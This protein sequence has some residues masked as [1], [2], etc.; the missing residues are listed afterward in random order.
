MGTN[1]AVPQVCKHRAAPMHEDNQ[2]QLQDK[3]PRPTP[4]VWVSGKS[5]S[6]VTCVTRVSWCHNA[7]WVLRCS[8]FSPSQSAFPSL[9][10]EH[11]RAGVGA[12]PVIYS[13]F[14]V[15]RQG[16][17]FKSKVASLDYSMSCT[18]KC[19]ATLTAVSQHRQ[20]SL[21]RKLNLSGCFRLTS[22]HCFIPLGD[23]INLG[24]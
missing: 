7:T 17:W 20:A 8:H 11:T 5:K 19:L 14:G 22:Q 23:F 18:L 15:Q 16:G 6:P 24:Q 13:A 3:T 1:W 10:T 12:T 4:R 21:Y 9:L 2:A